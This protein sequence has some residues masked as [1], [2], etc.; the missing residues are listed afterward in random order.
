M[1]K[2]LTPT[3]GLLQSFERSRDWRKCHVVNPI[4]QPPRFPH[5]CTTVTITGFA[6]IVELVSGQECSGCAWRFSSFAPTAKRARVGGGGQ[7]RQSILIGSLEP[8]SDRE[9]QISFSVIDDGF[10]GCS[11]LST[12]IALTHFLGG[13]ESICARNRATNTC[14]RM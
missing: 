6:S 13:I 4:P 2:N 8:E 5:P 14:R 12:V 10:L 3:R 7:E 9:Q 11:L 1:W